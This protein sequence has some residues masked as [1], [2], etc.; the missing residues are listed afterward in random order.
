MVIV[1]HAGLIIRVHI[2]RGKTKPGGELTWEKWSV[3]LKCILSTETWLERDCQILR[4]ELVGYHNCYIN[5][6]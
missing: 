3:L 5:I 4:S 2:Q 6:T 1:Q